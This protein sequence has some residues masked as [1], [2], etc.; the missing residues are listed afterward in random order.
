VYS[1]CAET[2]IF[3]DSQLYLWIG[4]MKSPSIQNEEFWGNFI[5]TLIG[6]DVKVGARC[7]D[8][9]KINLSR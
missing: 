9:T 6:A 7:T 3:A 5:Q 8:G 1:A 4:D 2:Y